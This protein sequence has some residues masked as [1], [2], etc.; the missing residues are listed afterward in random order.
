MISESYVQNKLVLSTK[1]T[2]CTTTFGA[3]FVI[4]I[5]LSITAASAPYHKR[6]TPT[7][8]RHP[9]GT[10]DCAK[11]PPRPRL[12]GPA[13]QAHRQAKTPRS[14]AA[15]ECNETFYTTVRSV[16]LDAHYGVLSK[17]AMFLFS[18]KPLLYYIIR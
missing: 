10:R 13:T 9:D 6:A 17:T 18:L 7:R 2:I 3:V 11:R 14:A 8:R 12:D 1:C 5:L 16:E 4:I 15:F